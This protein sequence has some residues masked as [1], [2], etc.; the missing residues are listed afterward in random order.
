MTLLAHTAIDSSV[1][2][3]RRNNGRRFNC[4]RQ[5]YTIMPIKL[6]GNAEMMRNCCVRV[7]LCGQHLNRFTTI[8]RHYTNFSPYKIWEIGLSLGKSEGEI[9]HNPTYPKTKLGINLG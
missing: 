5:R 6:K 3:Q 2:D 8:V 1:K 7:M 9:V 4:A